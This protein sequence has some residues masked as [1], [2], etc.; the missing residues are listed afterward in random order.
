MVIVSGSFHCVIVK[1]SVA[2]KSIYD[3]FF[4]VVKISPSIR[5]SAH[6]KNKTKCNLENSTYG[7]LSVSHV[8][9][10]D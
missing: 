9:Y 4:S 7:L 3:F 1:N 5:L 6:V 10:Y 8:G 2:A